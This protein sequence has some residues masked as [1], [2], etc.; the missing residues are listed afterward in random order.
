[1]NPE[2]TP[3]FWQQVQLLRRQ[4]LQMVEP[5]KLT[6][7]SMEVLR[8]PQTQAYIFDAF[9]NSDKVFFLPPDR[10]QFRVLKKLLYALEQSIFDPGEDVGVPVPYRFILAQYPH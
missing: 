5:D 3:S 6:L 4:Y 7:P 8:L 10:Y 9:F 2:S 1:M